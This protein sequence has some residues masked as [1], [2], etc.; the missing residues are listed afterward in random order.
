MTAR[1]K[2]TAYSMDKYSFEYNDLSKSLGKLKQTIKALNEGQFAEI[3]PDGLGTPRRPIRPSGYDGDPNRHFPTA[4]E[5]KKMRRGFSAYKSLT[6]EEYYLKISPMFFGEIAP[7]V[8][9]GSKPIP[10]RKSPDIEL[11]LSHLNKSFGKS[12]LYAL[13]QL[14]SNAGLLLKA[15][16]GPSPFA[17]KVKEFQQLHTTQGMQ[18]HQQNAASTGHFDPTKGVTGLQQ[19][20]NTGKTQDHVDINSA[21]QN[22]SALHQAGITSTYKSPHALEFQDQ[23]HKNAWQA[24]HGTAT[25]DE[26][27]VTRLH[28]GTAV[29]RVPHPDG[30]G[31]HMMMGWNGQQRTWAPIGGIQSGPNAANQHNQV[32]HW[33]D[34]NANDYTKHIASVLNQ[35]VGSGDKFNAQNTFTV[36]MGR[37]T[38]REAMH[39]GMEGDLGGA[40]AHNVDAKTF[41]DSL[42]NHGTS[43]MAHINNQQPAPTPTPT[44]DP[45]AQWLQGQNVDY[46]TTDGQ[47]AALNALYGQQDLNQG[48]FI[49]HAKDQIHSAIENELQQMQN[50]PKTSADMKAAIANG[51]A[52]A[53]LDEQS[54]TAKLKALDPRIDDAA[55]KSIYS[56]LA[57]KAFTPAYQQIQAEHNNNAL[58]ELVHGAQHDPNNPDP[59]HHASWHHNNAQAKETYQTF[60]RSHSELHK[61]LPTVE[62]LIGSGSATNPIDAIHQAIMNDASFQ[63]P[64]GFATKQDYADQLTDSLKRL[65]MNRLDDQRQYIAGTDEHAIKAGNS[66]LGVDVTNANLASDP[67]KQ[68]QYSQALTTIVGNLAKERHIG[69]HLNS[70]LNRYSDNLKKPFGDPSR[71]S[72]ASIIKDVTNDSALAKKYGD[73]ELGSDPG[74]LESLSKSFYRMN[75]DNDL[76]VMLNRMYGYGVRQSIDK[77]SKAKR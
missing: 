9:F 7:P 54:V 74:T 2:R 8:E 16:P 24:A 59:L 46:T 44:Q 40:N 26:S 31:G 17:Q 76:A 63:Q 77:M 53:G 58:G 20:P 39:Q 38:A 14:A 6:E 61:L 36:N 27:T 41:E 15:A 4:N 22:L 30:N 49:Q 70:I 21:F 23:A 5:K 75:T 45:H 28:D 12:R 73:M 64:R 1:F 34:A 13:R 62:Q 69:H 10:F 29:I 48:T 71:E 43:A 68:Q 60:F 3:G 37:S 65:P 47:H 50:P 33:G 18:Q 66:L 56:E 19:D 52:S 67:Q 25:A 35:H 32:T 42:N 11:F 57:S 51:M 55:A 72:L